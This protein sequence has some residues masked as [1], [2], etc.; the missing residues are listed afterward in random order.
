MSDVGYHRVID[1]LKARFA[2]FVKTGDDE[3]KIPSALRNI[4]YRIVRLLPHLRTRTKIRS[5]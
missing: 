4:T 5:P 3:S 2:H 1:E